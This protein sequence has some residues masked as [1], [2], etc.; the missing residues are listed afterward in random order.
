MSRSRKS[1]GPEKA[2]ILMAALVFGL[3][4]ASSAE[5]ALTYT[6]PTELKKSPCAGDSDGDCLDD[7][8]EANLA[9][10]MAPWYLYDEGEDC[11]GWRNGYGL[12]A[13]HFARQDFFQV[14]PE[15]GNV[16]GWSPKDDKAKWVK[17]SYFFNHPHDCGSAFGGHQGDAEHIRAA[18]YSYDLKTWYLYQVYYAHHDQDH[19]FSG[20]YL[21][22]RALA[23]GTSWISVAAD[24]DSHGSWPGLD[25]DSADCAGPE[26]DFCGANC[27][28]FVG[29]WRQALSS[30]SGRETVGV[31]RNIGGPT[32]EK[33]NPSVLAVMGNEAY[34]DLDVGHGLNREYWSPRSG[35]FGTFCGWECP[36]ANRNADGTCAVSVHGQ[37]A[38]SAPLSS[39]V[40]TS[41]F[42]LQPGSCQGRCGGSA[43]GC[44]CDVN[45]VNL[46]DCCPDA[47]AVCGVCPSGNG[48]LD[49]KSAAIFAPPSVPTDPEASAKAGS[50]VASLLPQ[51]QGATAVQ[52]LRTIRWML[53]SGDDNRLVFLFDDLRSSRVSPMKQ[54]AA[55][56][57]Q[58]LEELAADL[59]NAGNGFSEPV[60]DAARIDPGAPAPNTFPP[61]VLD[62]IG[63][64]R[65][66]S[67]KA[68]GP[69]GR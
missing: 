24:A 10:A 12:P 30:G 6:T 1:Y 20:S 42:Q 51:L 14:R 44:F 34:T 56:A 63:L 9:W 47:C 54:R 15:G 2:L 11:S 41:F 38:C 61:S 66:G 17:V 35:A 7:V 48:P 40:D 57:R 49:T 25:P 64:N 69:S 37:T 4:L 33:W 60:E 67:P 19:Y 39:K 52:Q 31:T 28:C 22:E 16:E 3:A 27:K 55:L 43:A 59:E 50:E 65:D 53:A 58:R 23:L 18:L 29:T 62:A 46:G 13:S 21:E 45:C 32:P 68:S 5:A 36:A 8:E 26:D